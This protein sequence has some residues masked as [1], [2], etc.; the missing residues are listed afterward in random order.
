MDTT[1]GDKSAKRMQRKSEHLRN[2]QLFMQLYVVKGIFPISECGHVTEGD[3]SA[4]VL[5][6][7]MVAPR[8]LMFQLFSV[9]VLQ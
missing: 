1:I 5:Q 6:T 3:I 4:I 2:E 7:N 8:Q 9:P